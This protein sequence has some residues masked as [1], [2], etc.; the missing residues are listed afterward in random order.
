MRPDAE[1]IELLRQGRVAKV[2]FNRPTV[3]NAFSRNMY[4]EV[5]KILEK[6]ETD[7]SVGA[8][9]FTGK[10]K[11]FSAGGDINRFKE[12]IESGQFLTEESIMWAAQLTRAIYLCSKPTIAMVNGAAAGAGFSCALACDYR[13]VTP[14][15]KMIMSFI[16][17]G[18]P[19]DTGSL[20]LLPKRIGQE[21]ADRMMM[22]GE[23][24]SG[25]RAVEIG[26]ASMLVENEKLDEIG[27]AF[28]EKLADRSTTAIAAQKRIQRKY[29]LDRLE[30]E[31]LDEA[32][33]MA[34]ASRQPDFKEAVYAFLEKRPPKF[35][36]G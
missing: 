20:F 6:L 24:V 5:Y 13:I 31:F 26:L 14:S 36:R 32:H 7:T 3:G 21:E 18:L 25:K 33:E 11:H 12:L 28:A 2:I 16:N 10:G 30:E 8:I 34:V 17:M 15:T 29:F 27:L 22:T 23:P 9:V 35:N 19:G 4:A 1:D